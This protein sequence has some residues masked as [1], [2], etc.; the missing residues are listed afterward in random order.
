MAL[1]RRGTFCQIH[2]TWFKRQPNILL[3]VQAGAG[4]TMLQM[5]SMFNM[6]TC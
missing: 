4:N 2:P 5:K 6:Y 1:K 3:V